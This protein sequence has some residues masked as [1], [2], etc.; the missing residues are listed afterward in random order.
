[1][2]LKYKQVAQASPGDSSG[3]PSVPERSAQGSCSF[4]RQRC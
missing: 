4:G 2:E 3:G 1:M